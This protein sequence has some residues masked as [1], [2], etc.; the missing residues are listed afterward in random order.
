MSKLGYLIP[1]WPAQTHAFFAREVA[2]LEG[3]GNEVFL[4]STRKPPRGACTHVFAER[5]R[6]RTHYVFPPRMSVVRQ[7][8]VRSSRQTRAALAYLASLTHTGARDFVCR[9]GLLL[10]AAELAAYAE[11]CGLDHVH[12]HSCAMAAHLAALSSLIGGPTYSL[13]LH[14]DLPVYGVDHA[15]KMRHARFV[16]TVTEPLRQQVIAEVGVPAANVPIIPMGVDVD[17][18]VPFVDRRP[19]ASKQLLMVTVA[20]LNQAKGHRHVLDAMAIA[21]ASGIDVRYVIAGDGP[22]RDAVVARIEA[23]SLTPHVAVVG[24]L[25]EQDV[26]LL[27]RRADVFVLASEGIGEA[28]PVSVMEAMATGLPV[29]A[30]RIG[31]TPDMITD[32]VDGFLIAQRDAHGLA[33]LLARLARDAGYRT[34]IGLAARKRAVAQFD[35]RTQASRL[36]AAIHDAHAHLARP[37]LSETRRCAVRQ[38]LAAGGAPAGSFDRGDEMGPVARAY[39]R[40]KPSAVR[41]VGSA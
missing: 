2:A 32:G 18:F 39:S 34:M 13:T 1:E 31:G 41:R 23:L 17:S 29:I 10:C 11:E 33:M 20:R 36:H 15:L 38:R 12:V 9:F 40:E 26:L 24:A 30:S 25:N 14:G 4:L 3:L 7:C 27:L 5:V 16:A 28:A 22:Y 37:R 35:Y 21:R 6:A 19:R 8:L